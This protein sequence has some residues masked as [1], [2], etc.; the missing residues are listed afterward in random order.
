MMHQRLLDLAWMGALAEDG[1]PG[2]TELVDITRF[3]R[4][5]GLL[6]AEKALLEA[7][8]DLRRHV[9]AHV[10]WVSLGDEIGRV[11]VGG[12]VVPNRNP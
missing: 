4:P 6:R 2:P 8:E 5:E 9:P 10:M 12:R 1:T 11:G 3:P 7:T